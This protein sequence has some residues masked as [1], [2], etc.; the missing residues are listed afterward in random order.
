MSE[1][2]NCGTCKHMRKDSFDSP[3]GE[4]T[5]PEKN[6][7]YSVLRVY[8]RINAE[9][10]LN[11]SQWKRRELIEGPEK[12]P[13]YASISAQFS[14]LENRIRIDAYSGDVEIG[15]L[16]YEAESRLLDWHFCRSRGFY[17][18]LMDAMSQADSS[19]L[20][21][22]ARAFPSESAAMYKFKHDPNY[23]EDLIARMKEGK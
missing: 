23:C 22:L 16:T 18:T 12:E 20:R 8:T 7:P 10:G 14:D 4:C 13:P 5:W 15:T 3:Y 11:C 1:E 2:Q 17:F 19:N 6:L 9:D 21:K